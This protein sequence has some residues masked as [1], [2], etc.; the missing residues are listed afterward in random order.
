MAA[1]KFVQRAA[2][3]VVVAWLA[4]NVADAADVKTLGPNGGDVRRL[5]Y[6]PDNPDRIYLGTSSGRLYVSNNGGASWTQFARLGS[7]FDYVLDNITIDP[8]H[9]RTMYVAGWSI[10]RNTGELFRSRDGGN[11]WTSLPG[12]NGKSIR[13]LAMAP[14]DSKILVTGALDGVFRSNDGGDSWKLISPPNHPDI[15]NIQSVA[16]DP[17]DPDIVYAGTWHLAWKTAD[18]GQSWRQIKRGMIDDSDVFSII[19]D[20]DRPDI[21]YASACSGIYRSQNAGELFTKVQ[22]IPFSARRTRVLKQDPNHPEIVYAGTTEGLWRTNDSGVHWTRISAPQLIINDVMV[23]PRDSNHVMLATD[24]SG[25]MRSTDNGRS[26]SQSNDGFTHRQVT[27]VLVDRTN[28]QVVYAGVVNDKQ[29]GGVFVSRDSGTNWAQLS[30]GLGGEDVFTLGQDSKG[31]LYAGTNR[32]LFRY[33]T[34]SKMWVRIY[35]AGHDRSFQVNALAIDGSNLIAVGPS[36]MVFSRNGGQTFAAQPQAGN[37]GF[38]AVNANGS[39]MVAATHTAMLSSTDGG[40]RWNSVHYPSVSYIRN[41]MVDHSGQIWMTSPQGAFYRDPSGNWE[42]V[43]GLSDLPVAFAFDPYGNRVLAATTSSGIYATQ[44]G[45]HWEMV[46]NAGVPVRTL[47]VKD[48]QVFVGTM[49]DGVISFPMSE[50]H[51]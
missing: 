42:K 50:S 48:G 16:I 40:R 44:D 43:Q 35:P 39:A 49:F 9:P 14:S 1:W 18:A 19:V 11:S 32:G 10:E 36:G 2:L 29:F 27:A 8:R 37:Q 21:V 33:M 12:M 38:M 41:M 34:K 46:A 5:A 31:Q 4:A 28:P 6:A 51:R 25:I 3:V 24:R 7:N 47:A 30:L 26:F 22:G 20:R 13:S 23:D 17:K 15:K 45:K